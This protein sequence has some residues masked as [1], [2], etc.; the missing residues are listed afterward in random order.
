MNRTLII[1]DVHGCSRELEDL[2][3]AC[4]FSGGDRLVFVGDLVAKGPDS[5][6]VLALYRRLGAVSV[7]GNHDQAVLRWEDPAARLAVPEK[8]PPHLRLARELSDDDWA[9]LQSLPL[10]LRLPEFQTLIVHGG[11][12]PGLPLEEH[13][14]ELLMNMRTLRPDGTGSR[15]P[16]DGVLWGS[17]WP[18]PERVIFGHHATAG[19]QRHPFALGLD[20]GCVYGK[21]LTA[22]VLPEERLISVPARA[23]YVP[24]DGSAP[25]GAI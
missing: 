21:E 1:G 16:E 6:G 20:T 14:A 18:G 24:I 19:L 3:D 25:R 5:R 13:D 22:Y 4:A 8:A 15:R 23:Q 10:W 2:L 9:V 17:R 7:R 11:V 12:V